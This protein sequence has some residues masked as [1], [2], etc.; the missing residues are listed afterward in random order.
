M[1]AASR[2]TVLAE[3]LGLG[4]ALGM[5]LFTSFLFALYLGGA[6]GTATTWG[7][8]A[9]ALAAVASGAGALARTRRTGADT[10]RGPGAVIAVGLALATAQVAFATWMTLRAPLSYWDSWTTWGFKARM[11]ALGGPPLSYFRDGNSGFIHPDYPLNLPLAE[12]ALLRFGGPLGLPL[13]G[14][15]GPAC[16]LALLLLV[17]SGLSRVYGRS[18]AA[19]ATGT[20]ALVPDLAHWAAMGYADVPLAMY[21][22]AAA[23]YLLLW[24]R[25]RRLIDALLVGLLAGGAVWTKK[26]GMT[27]AALL[28][29]V[30]VGGELLRSDVRVAARLWSSVRVAPAALV[31]PLPW[32]LFKATTDPIGSDY[33]PLTPAVFIAHL[34]RLPTIVLLIGREMLNLSHWSLFWVALAGLPVVS[35]WWLSLCGRGLLALLLGQVGILCTLPYVFSD[36]QPY[37]EHIHRSADRLLVQATPLALLLFVETVDALARRPGFAG[38]ARPAWATKRPS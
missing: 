38:K 20:L 37:T 12:A 11:F 1:S 5:A 7:A 18:T 2:A 32:L 27:I 36:W 35:V 30:Y 19:L 15:L 23:L 14:L 31:V 22:G 3:M 16:L 9:L 13:A 25:Q 24:W 21:A 8:L 26:E 17:Y 34:G 6:L 10:E 33:W 4:W 28:V 29:L